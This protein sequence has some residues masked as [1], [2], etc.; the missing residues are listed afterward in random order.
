MKIDKNTKYLGQLLRA[1]FCLR[2][3][4]VAHARQLTF[5]TNSLWLANLV[6]FLAVLHYTMMHQKSP[7]HL[8]HEVTAPRALFFHENIRRVIF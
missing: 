2:F 8:G 4:I 7:I 1:R 3:E 6:T 5:K